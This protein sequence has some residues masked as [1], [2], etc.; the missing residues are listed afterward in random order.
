MNLPAHVQ[1]LDATPLG[2]TLWQV[3]LDV[4]LAAGDLA[5]LSPAE[6]DRAARFRFA[7]DARRYQVSHVA[8]RLVLAQTLDL[9]D[10]AQLTWQ[11]HAQGKPYLP[12]CDWHFNL[13]HSGD[14]ALIGVCRDHPIGVDLELS[15]PMPD[16]DDLARRHFT[17]AEH[18][19]YMSS[20]LNQRHAT[21]LRGWTRKEACLKALGSGLSIEPHLFEAGL[22]SGLQTTAIP[23]QEGLF[24]VDVISLTPPLDGTAALAAVAQL[25]GFTPPACETRPAPIPA[26]ASHK[27]PAPRPSQ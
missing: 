11:H 12:T 7:H 13:S 17:A 26:K 16:A 25:R 1:R 5:M 3:S 21:F 27:A 20:P 4:P 6:Q 24:D 8:L 14:W 19:A 2:L 23:S 15:A 10:P 9:A 18:T 22:H